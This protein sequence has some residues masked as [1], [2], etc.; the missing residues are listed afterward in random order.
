MLS[1][2][3][4]G[5]AAT[6]V[7]PSIIYRTITTSGNTNAAASVT[8]IDT[9]KRYPHDAAERD[10]T[11]YPPMKQPMTPGKLRVGVVPEEW[12]QFMYNKTGV[13]GPY[14]LFWGGLTTI[15]S[16]EYFVPWVDTPEHLVFLG[17]FIY[18]SK[19]VA[20]QIGAY[21][22][23]GVKSEDDAYFNELAE[24]TIQVDSQIEGKENLK[25]LPDANVLIHDAKRE[26]VHL[27]LEAA[28]RERM[29]TVHTE[30]KKRLDYQVNINNVHSRFEREQAINYIID[31]VRSSI[32]AN[33]QKEAFASGLA[34]L[35]ALSQ[36]HAA[37]I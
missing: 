36:K 11:N 17:M 4:R 18:F 15:L 27:Q 26:N 13:T 28:L 19:K 33:Q 34:Q 31:G 20:P 29:H 24:S 25:S 16:K 21:L 9:V 6:S 23:K 5:L 32:G 14:I 22:D 2:V 7:R 10:M 8:A 37:T 35:K 30:V 12:F 1:R 3:A